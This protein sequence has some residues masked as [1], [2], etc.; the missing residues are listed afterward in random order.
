MQKIPPSPRPL[1][2]KSKY[3]TTSLLPI[4]Q[5]GV[6]K[7][8]KKLST[9]KPAGFDMTPPKL[10]YIAA[11]YMTGALSQSINNIKKGLSLDNVNSQ[12]LP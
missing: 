7:I 1:Q 10:I 4:S 11:N 5:Q 2:K 6:E 9:E 3:S 8:R 12:L